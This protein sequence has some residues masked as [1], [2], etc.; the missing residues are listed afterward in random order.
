VG[1]AAS[2]SAVLS[3]FVLTDVT[4]VTNITVR[5][6]AAERPARGWHARKE[7]LKTYF[8]IDQPKEKA[9][10]VLRWSSVD[11]DERAMQAHLALRAR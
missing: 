11:H 5:R 4:A 8:A 10:Y 9:A 2:A 6:L 1:T 3:Y 7:N